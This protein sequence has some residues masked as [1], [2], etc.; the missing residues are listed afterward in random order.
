MDSVQSFFKFN[1]DM[2][3]SETRRRLLPADLPVYTE[4]RD[5]M[6]ARYSEGSSVVNSLVADGCVIEGTVENCILA[7]GVH[8]AA[9]AVVRNCIIMQDGQVHAG[10]EI[11]NCILDKQTVIEGNAR[12]L[13]PAE[14]PIV[15]P[16]KVV[17]NR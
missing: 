16:K 1:M 11:A 6:P 4:V 12:L 14:Y 7:R 2:L 5:E 9:G 17:V 15:I 10:A 8:I 3:S 13:G